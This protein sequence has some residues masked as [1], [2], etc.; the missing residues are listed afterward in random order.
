MSSDVIAIVG[1]EGFGYH[2]VLAEE[3]ARGQRFIVDLEVH[4]DLAGAAADDDLSM[5]VDYS[6][7]AREAL[8]VIEGE[9]HQLIETV[10]YL[11][12]QGALAHD[13]VE[14]VRVTVHKPE[15]PV[16]VRFGDVSVSMVRP[17]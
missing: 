9:P 15:A 10:A 12:A 5:T 11:V 3:R 16:G 17:R 7:L 8:S 6:V 1:I 4:L 13:G 14:S 2:G